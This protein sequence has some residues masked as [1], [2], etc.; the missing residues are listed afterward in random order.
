MHVR[1]CLSTCIHHVLSLLSIFQCEDRNTIQITY[2]GKTNY[3]TVNKNPSN[4]DKNYSHDLI[5]S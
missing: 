4:H 3:I 5:S 2:K 1:L